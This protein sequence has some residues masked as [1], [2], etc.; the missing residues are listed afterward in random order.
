MLAA[1][2]RHS[3]LAARV[4]P[5]AETGWRRGVQRLRLARLALHVLALRVLGLRLGLGIRRRR[6][7][8]RALASVLRLALLRLAL[9]H[10]LIRGLL[11]AAGAAAGRLARHGWL[12]LRH[13][14]GGRLAGGR[15][16]RGCLTGGRL[17]GGCLA[18]P[19][20]AGHWLEPRRRSRS[21]LS[22]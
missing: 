2:A 6:G 4:L 7:R 10:A 5:V 22:R 11:L 8:L 21:W 19:G 3:L 9:A 17:A 12:C 20:L 16:A 15:L 18:W 13:Q 14:A 1:P